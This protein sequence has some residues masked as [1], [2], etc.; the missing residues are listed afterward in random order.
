MCVA[1]CADDAARCM[2]TVLCDLCCVFQR[3]KMVLILVVAGAGVIVLVAVVSASLTVRRVL[4]RN[5]YLV[6]LGLLY[7]FSS[8]SISIWSSLRIGWDLR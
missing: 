8:S 7:V 4:Y 3:E 6:A 2:F 1:L 5:R